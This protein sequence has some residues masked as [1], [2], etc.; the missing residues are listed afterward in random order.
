MSKDLKE[1]TEIYYY[2]WKDYV[3]ALEVKKEVTRKEAFKGNLEE[4]KNASEEEILQTAFKLFSE[5]NLHQMDVML[6]EMRFKFGYEDTLVSDSE[7]KFDEEIS[8]A[9]KAL[10][11]K[12][13]K[14]FYALS[15]EKKFVAIDTK[16]IAEFE[17]N[18][19]KGVSQTVGIGA[20]T[21]QLERELNKK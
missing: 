2:E 14:Q 18:F 4:L 15:K 12:H 9:F 6:L 21:E 8:S 1:L 7:I 16:K 5:Q 13:T 3:E 17:E 10:I 11:T 19:Y 20:L